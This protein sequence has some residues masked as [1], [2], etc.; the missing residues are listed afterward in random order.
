MYEAYAYS[1][2]YL[3][4]VVESSRYKTG[5]CYIL[6]LLEAEPVIA[7]CDFWWEWKI[8]DSKQPILHKVYECS[9]FGWGAETFNPS[10]L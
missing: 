3:D 9:D 4:G 8:F 1:A 10:L 7:L 5:D 2:Y 6:M